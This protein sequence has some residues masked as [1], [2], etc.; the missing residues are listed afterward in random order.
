MSNGVTNIDSVTKF[1][2]YVDYA[3]EIG[4]KAMAFSEHGSVFE[5]YH[6]KE[7]IE[8]AGMKYIHAEEFYV[9]EH[10]NIK[11][12]ETGD[13]KKIRDNYHCVL[14]ARNYEGFKELNKLASKSFNR[15]KVIIVDDGDHYYYAPRITFDEL[16]GTSNNIIIT[17]ACLGGI[18]NKGN[19]EIRDR[20]LHFMYINNS[21][22]FLEIQHHNVKDQSDYNLKLV[23]LSK[24][25]NIPLIAGT[26]T[27][28]LNPKHVKGRSI[29]QK[30]KGIFFEDEGGWD[31]T[32]K[33][34]DEL[35]AAYKIQNVLAEDIYLTAIE[36]TNKM[37]DMVE[38]FELDKDIKYPKI[39]ENPLNVYKNKVNLAYKNHKY[40]KERYS[41]D[42]I[43]KR[44]QDEM[45]TYQATKSIDFM[46]LQTY[47]REWE[48]EN[49]IQCGY[50]RGS[51]SGSEIAYMLGITEMD[52][53]KFN[54]N[55]FRFMNPSR[56]TNADIDT[57]YSSKDREKV[58]YFLLHDHMKLPNVRTSEIITFNTIALKGA[59]KDV[60]RALD[61][62]IQETQEISDAV[63]LED[64]KWKID[65]MWREKYP[66]LFEYVDI[67]VGT[68]VSIGSHPSGVL[69]SDLNIEEEIG[70]CSL[71]SSDYP[72]SMLNMK[73]L[74]ALKL[75]KLDILGLDNL[76]VINETCKLI[77]IDRLTPDNVDL[78]DEK[79]W[80]S[81][82]DD[83]TLIFQWESDSAQAYLKRLLSDE[84]I[85]IMKKYIKDFSYIKT[86][87]FG[88][89]LI[90]P[91]C[92]SYRDDVANGTF[93]DNGL[94]ELDEFLAP[95]MGHVTMQEDIMQFLVRFCGYSDA[96]SDTVRRG[97]A[98]KYGTEKFLPEIESRF[99]EYSSK[100]YGIDK[101]KCAEVIKPF[102]QVILDASKYSFSWNHSDA[103]S[104]I[105]Y[106]CGYLRYYYPLE[107]LT[108]SFNVFRDKE[109]KIKSITNYC[110]KVDI[111]ISAI[112]FRHS[113]AD[114]TCDKNTNIIYKGMASIKYLNEKISN[115]L[116]DLGQYDYT[117]FVDLLNEMLDKTGNYNTDRLYRAYCVANGIEP[118]SINSRQ[119]E[120]LIQLN[121]FNEFGKAGKLM[122]IY[123]LYNTLYGKKQFK[124]DK[125]PVPEE[126]IKK[127]S[128]ETE[129][130]Y[131]NIDS[132][133]LLK[134]MVSTTEDKELPLKITLQAQNDYLGYIEYTN[135]KLKDFVYVSDINTNY[136][137]KPILYDLQ[138]GNI[139]DLRVS[140]ANY[141]K[142]PYNTGDI[143]QV[144][145]TSQ[146]P[147]K[148][149]ID[150]KFC[151]I[152]GEYDTWINSYRI[153]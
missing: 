143:M 122:K 120:I 102:L 125:L 115:S 22:C 114:Y 71:S 119:I 31:L 106:I 104:C 117:D 80:K 38:V 86:F 78:D 152:V 47:M 131:K 69:V 89:G 45:S 8:E 27:H 151:T 64:G 16:M 53:I 93:Y 42:I 110:K 56:V 148:K 147:K 149:K 100:T 75:V 58:K 96:E 2:E 62:P 32:F 34:Y 50:G 116:Y 55:F 133:S 44:V 136:L 12:E 90:R 1:Q 83:T 140:S 130:M 124:K 142:N 84:T 95:T 28:S 88:N 99:I 81:I 126:I 48:R 111:P 105:G 107:F 85:A 113:K 153:R 39:Y 141:R 3:K 20:L 17:S 121:F 92:A 6:K 139:V 103:Y 123:E 36:N 41:K 63:Y 67:V 101:E 72:V 40:V 23:Q 46:L 51:V 15:A 127:Y 128:D 73:E 112:K 10:L 109:D 43:K 65:S 4:M 138:T 54:L 25:Y 82:R 5:W 144:L 87:S 68:I 18:L 137:S 11:D 26:D 97:I 13:L 74:D 135:D 145:S 91:A 52:S 9:T 57:D 24:K 108:A 30:S 59:I 132:I 94:K 150:G 76:G 79:V 77:G 134:E 118:I 37:A 146:S 29:L 49:G 61:L 21:R 60:G 7:A 66:E 98:K 19:K 129:K 35:C 70:L 14:I 33:T